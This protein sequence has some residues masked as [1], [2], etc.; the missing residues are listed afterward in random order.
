MSERLEIKNVSKR[1]SRSSSVIERGAEYIGLKKPNPVVHALD[2]VNLTINEGEV[3]G[4]VGESGCGK[5]TL[6]R[7]AAGLISPSEGSVVVRGQKLDELS[8][9]EAKEASLKIQM[10]FQDPSSSLNPRHRLSEIIG[11]APLYHNLTT[12]RDLKDY[13]SL[14]MQRAGLDPSMAD[15]FPHQLSGG[16]R[17]RVGIARALAVQPDM[18]ICDESVAALDVSIQAQ[19]LNLFLDL[20]SELNLTY[21]FISH[22][23]SVVEHISDRI[24]VMYLG[25]VVEEAPVVE[26]FQHPAHPYTR[27]LLNERPSLDPVPRQYSTIEGEIPSPLSPPSGCHF[28]PRCP[29]AVERCRHEKPEL[30]IIGNRHKSACHLND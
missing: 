21:A 29:F 12:S 23:L 3:V 11:T 24:V 2:N 14:Q 1:F 5:S 25:R 15:R 28:H 6:G 16:Q 10:I 17:Q 26:L 7:V 20:R 18:L 19:I 9:A 13:V 27:A 4:I 30:R 8:K 22:D